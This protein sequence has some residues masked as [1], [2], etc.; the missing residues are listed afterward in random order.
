MHTTM[1]VEIDRPIDEVFDYTVHNVA[2][3]SSIVVQDEA[4]DEMPLGVGSRFRVTTE[5]KG[6]RMEFDGVV[7]RHEPPNAHAVHMRGPQFDIEAEYLFEDIGGRTCVTQHS[8][9]HGK[10][11]LKVLFVILGPLTKKSSR[12]ALE[13]E[14]LNLKRLLEA[15]GSLQEQ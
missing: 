14:L 8:T 13:S 9:V 12:R 4:V 15:R 6:R 1:S 10:G 2:E 5:E 3:W 7:T 11:F